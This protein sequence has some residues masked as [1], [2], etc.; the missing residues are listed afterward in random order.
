MERQDIA[1]KMEGVAKALLGEPNTK[2]RRG[3]EWRYGRKGSLCIDLSKGTWFDHEAGEGGGVLDLI[4]RERGG[5]VPEALEWLKGELGEYVPTVR[6][7]SNKDAERERSNLRQ[8]ALKLWREAMP[9]KG[10][11]AERYLM[12]RR[13]GFGAKLDDIRFHPRCPFGKDADG[14]T[15]YHPC[16]VALVRNPGDLSPMGI[17]R[18]ALTPDGRKIDRKMLGPCHGGVVVLA[19]HSL[20]DEVCIAEGIETALAS[21]KLFRRPVWATL[22]AGSMSAFEPLGG[23]GSLTIYADNDAAGAEA[24]QKCASVWVESGALVEIEMPMQDGWDFADVLA[25]Y[26]RGELVS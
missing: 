26:E 20:D 6:P 4:Q 5:G 22:S 3:T 13:I 16:M 11:L 14:N 8:S 2:Q 19:P 24:S 23:V 12:A 25:A 7:V 15:A 1:A 9:A 17:H 18:T 21:A 10:T